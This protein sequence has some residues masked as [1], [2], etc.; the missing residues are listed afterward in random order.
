M[1]EFKGSKVKMYALNC[2]VNGGG[3]H[4]ASMSFDLH[5]DECPTKTEARENADLFVLAGNLAQKHDPDTWEAK[6]DLWDDV[7]KY[8]Q[9][10]YEP[11]KEKAMED[12][13]NALICEGIRELILKTNTLTKEGQA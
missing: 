1:G 12:S 3:K 7:V 10:S 13:D 5:G 8:L 11:M 2:S 9:M 4:I 6:L